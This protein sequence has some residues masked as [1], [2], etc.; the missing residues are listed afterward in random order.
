[1]EKHFFD[2]ERDEDYFAHLPHLKFRLITII[3]LIMACALF[4]FRVSYLSSSTIVLS[5]SV[6]F[7][8]FMV[9]AGIRLIFSKSI[10]FSKLVMFASLLLFQAVEFGQSTILNLMPITPQLVAIVIANL[11]FIVFLSMIRD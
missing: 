11:A 8:L 7:M 1:V 6:G 9:G 3:F 10:L 4:L 2:W 5:A